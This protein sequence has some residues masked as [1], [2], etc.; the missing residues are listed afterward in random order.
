M[1]EEKDGLVGDVSVR[2]T[3][4]AT[5]ERSHRSIPTLEGF[6]MLRNVL[7]S[8]FFIAA[9]SPL[10]LHGQSTSVHKARADRILVVKSSHTMTLYADGNP[11]KV[12]HVWI[13]RGPGK[14][15]LQQGDNETPEGKYTINGRNAHSTAYKSL[16]ISYPNAADRERARQLG[17]D[18]GG[19][20]MIHGL[21]PGNGWVKP[22]Q[23]LPDWTFGCI[24]LTNT[25]MDEVWELVPNGTPIEIR[26]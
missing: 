26:H 22:G 2:S 1:M 8:I 20:I 16:R 4:I 14:P 13:G 19:D 6:L 17:V 23:P 21:P 3:L 15:K 18:P 9:C 5:N 10:S 11:L 25:E 12:Y 24:A 7:R